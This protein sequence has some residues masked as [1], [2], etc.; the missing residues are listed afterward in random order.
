[1]SHSLEFNRATLLE[2]MSL[3]QGSPVLRN[4]NQV[5]A[6]SLGFRGRQEPSP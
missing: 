5:Q 2:R 6:I 3:A 4:W 1:M